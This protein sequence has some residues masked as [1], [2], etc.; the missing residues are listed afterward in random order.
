MHINVSR[1]PKPVSVPDVTGQPFANAKSALQGA[2]FVVTRTDVQSSDPKGTVVSTD[3]PPGSSVPNCSKI[4][5]TVSKGPGTSQ[6]PDV[7][8]QNQSDATTI[9]KQAGFSVGV[10]TQPVTDPGSDGIVISQNPVGGQQGTSG[11]TV[12]ITVGQ[13][14]QSTTTTDTTLTP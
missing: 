10:V 3:P 2:G 6:I 4:T 7:T 8:G 14:T 12:V 9:L 5:V 13:L 1:G 11:E